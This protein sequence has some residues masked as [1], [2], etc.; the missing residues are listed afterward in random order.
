V[1]VS[2]PGFGVKGALADAGFPRYFRAAAPSVHQ[3]LKTLDPLSLIDRQPGVPRGIRLLVPPQPPILG[4][5][6]PVTI[7]ARGN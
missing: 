1:A 5:D 3:R 2:L 7:T 6:H 4:L